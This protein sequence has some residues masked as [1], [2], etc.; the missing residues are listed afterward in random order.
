[1]SLN[2]K[3]I[4]KNNKRQKL[5]KKENVLKDLFALQL[6]DFSFKNISSNNSVSS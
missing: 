3:T 1:M 4:I 6:V 2:Q 5:N